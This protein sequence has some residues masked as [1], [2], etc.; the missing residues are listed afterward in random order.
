MGVTVPREQRPHA[1]AADHSTA[2]APPA[3]AL[4][5]L[6][7]LVERRALCIE[8][9]RDAHD[10]QLK[11]VPLERAAVWGDLLAP[12][13]TAEVLVALA[14][15]RLC[16]PHP[17][18]QLRALKLGGGVD[19]G[20]DKLGVGSVVV[21]NAVDGEDAV[22]VTLEQPLDHLRVE[23][24]AREA[25]TLL[26][27]QDATGVMAKER[28]RFDE[29]GPALGRFSPA[30]RLFIPAQDPHAMALGPVADSHALGLRAK[31]LPVS[32]TTDVSD[33]YGA[34]C[35]RWAHAGSTAPDG[36]S[37]QAF[38]SLD[39]KKVDPLGIWLCMVIAA[40]LSRSENKRRPL[41]PGQGWRPVH[42]GSSS[43]QL[44]SS[45]PARSVLSIRADVIYDRTCFF[46]RTKRNR[47][48]WRMPA[49]LVAILRAYLSG[50]FELGSDGKKT[51]PLIGQC[52]A[53]AATIA[54]GT[55]YKPCAPL[56][57]KTVYR[58]WRDL[59]AKR[60]L[61][62]V[63]WFRVEG[64]SVVRWLVWERPLDEHTAAAMAA[65]WHYREWRR[66]QERKLRL[67]R[68]DE[69]PGLGL[70]ELAQD[71]SGAAAL[72]AL[73]ERFLEV[74]AFWAPASCAQRFGQRMSEQE[75]QRQRAWEYETTAALQLLRAGDL[76]AFELPQLGLFDVRPG[77]AVQI[78]PD[79]VSNK[80]LDLGSDPDLQDLKTPPVTPRT[81]AR[82]PEPRPAPAEPGP[83]AVVLS[84]P[85]A[86][87]LEAV[88]AEREALE[89]KL[90]KYMRRF[91]LTG[92]GFRPFRCAS[93]LERDLEGL[94]YVVETIDFLRW[95]YASG[96][97]RGKPIV[98]LRSLVNAALEKDYMGERIREII[99][100]S[101]QEKSPPDRNRALP[102]RTLPTGRTSQ[103]GLLPMRQRFCAHSKKL[104]AP[105]R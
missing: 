73:V 5:E 4:E 17:E 84:F 62:P 51:Y 20:P 72:A 56:S 45:I 85:S 91:E 13:R 24:V 89:S 93:S 47:C 43:M 11:Q 97:M 12:W 104:R 41:S 30:D 7:N 50:S 63:A 67:V 16:G 100:R 87:Q 31:L 94:R 37:D 36:S 79:P 68:A 74:R 48:G 76:D 60:L 55:D 61:T 28:D 90:R 1:G 96:E 19:D 102:A 105:Q 8:L 39:R 29:R 64:K 65:Y 44:G 3:A 21:R 92:R 53:S 49:V 27:E 46:A 57:P 40:R 32:G 69:Q 34:L 78:D 6:L 52:T 25:I 58:G 23:H 88:F 99:A 2:P 35:R 101:R 10:L 33:P 14:L 26:Y 80:D 81:P 15:H 38:R 59:V 71:T 42:R 95:D 82:S 83:G 70:A 9:E 86:P 22:A 103:N 66:R 54:N 77:P 98:C 18:D 75:E